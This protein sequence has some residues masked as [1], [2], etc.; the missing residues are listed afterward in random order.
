MSLSR[1]PDVGYFNVANRWLRP[2]PTLAHLATRWGMKDRAVEGQAIWDLFW[3]Q[4]DDVMEA[5]HATEE[6]RAWY[7]RTIGRILDLRGAS[8]FLAKYP[9]LSLRMDWLDA[10]FPDCYFVHIIRDW[11]ATVN[12][13]VVRRSRREDRSHPK[14][15]GWFGMRVPGWTEMGD[16]PFEIAAGRQYRTTT[17][18]IEQKG[19]TYPDRYM[20]VWFGDLYRDPAH[21]VRKI[22]KFCHLPWSDGFEAAI[23]RGLKAGNQKWRTGL[24]PAMIETI[25]AE[26]PEFFESH[27]EPD[28]TGS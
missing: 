5:E 18:W 20:Q 19:P 27:E 14:H 12:S 6:A 1:H 17:K 15:G 16:L 21:E 10:L 25:R 8:R 7:G 4:E 24:D 23:P 9:R 26:D 3:R 22:A 28:E 11:R 13:T 2:F